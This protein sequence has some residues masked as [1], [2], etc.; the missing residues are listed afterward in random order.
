MKHTKPTESPAQLV[1][2][3]VSTL[4]WGQS[5][6]AWDVARAVGVPP[7]SAESALENLVKDGKLIKEG[8]Y[9]AKPPLVF[10]TWNEVMEDGESSPIRY[11]QRARVEVTYKGVV[12]KV[13][14]SVPAL[15][16]A[17]QFR[18]IP[19]AVTQDDVDCAYADHLRWERFRMF[20]KDA[21]IPPGGRKELPDGSVE[22]YQPD[23][24]GGPT[25]VMVERPDDYHPCCHAPTDMGHSFGCPHSPENM[26]ETEARMDNY[27]EYQRNLPPC[28]RGPG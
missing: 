26:S 22:F 3:W 8:N 5:A 21:G 1:E 13:R 11:A 9:Y 12:L 23:A 7:L 25:L 17:K 18:D 14:P 16:T 10:P 28:V 15:R 24:M 27:E 6:T 20:C 2:T 4:K 19:V